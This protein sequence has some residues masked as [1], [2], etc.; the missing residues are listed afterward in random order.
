MPWVGTWSA[1]QQLTEP[2]NLPPAP[3][4]AG[5]TLRQIIYVSI[6]G[7]RLRF[8]FSNEYGTSPLT[9]LAARVAKA[10][11]AS[12]IL[13][14]SDVPLR[15]EGQP[16]VSIPAGQTRVSD[17]FDFALEPLTRLTVSTHFGSVSEAVTG[18]PGSRTTSFLIEGDA[19]AAPFLKGAVTTDH[20]YVLSGLDVM[21]SADSRA[22]VI[23]SSGEASISFQRSSS[24]S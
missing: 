23:L 22:I 1:P 3:G 7:T 9:I 4:L 13:P 16:S 21:G 14:H 18:H 20:W 19:T 17:P 5:N 10:G 8:R 11:E 24:R 6:G 12:R 2:H 15:F